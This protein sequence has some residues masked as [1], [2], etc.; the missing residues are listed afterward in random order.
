MSHLPF[1]GKVERIPSARRRRLHF[2]VKTLPMPKRQSLPIENQ[3]YISLDGMTG[4]PC[5]QITLLQLL[6]FALKDEISFP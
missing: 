1:F 5:S 6:N 3:L 2:V 4:A